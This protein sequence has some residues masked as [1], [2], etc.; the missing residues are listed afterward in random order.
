MPIDIVSSVIF[1][2]P[3][4]IPLW[5]H[6]KVWVPAAATLAAA[7]YYFGGATNTWTR[8]LNGRVYIVTGGTSGLGAQA[9][10]EL[11]RRGAQLILLTRAPADAWTVDFIDD[12]RERTNNFMIYAEP[13]DLLLLY[14][15]RRFATKWLDNNPPRRLDGVVCCAAECIPKGRARQVLADGVEAQ[16]ATNYLAHYHLLTLLRPALHVQPPDR[17]V[18]VVLATC[19]SQVVG[20]VREDD[21]LWEQRTY[22]AARPWRVYG[23]LK[24]LLGMFGRLLQRGVAAYERP[25]KAPCNIKVSVVNPGVM[26]TPSTRRFLSMGS[27]WGLMLYVL[28]WPFWWVF[29]KSASQ[30]VQSVLFAL[31]A[32]VLGAQDG[33]N[34]IQECRIV[35]R[36][37]RE[38]TDWDLQDRVFE[39]TAELI[40]TLEKL[41]AIERKKREKAEGKEPPKAD[42]SA[43][44]QT[45]E[46]LDSQLAV[47]RDAMAHPL[48]TG[49]LFQRTGT[50]KKAKKA[51]KK[52]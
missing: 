13:C 6:V 9:A 21:L 17:D 45:T 41:S 18:R 23:T 15:V 32:P 20:E 49:D 47:M 22:P 35:T 27:V 46:D 26:R 50:G 1:D 34:F 52:A 24:L 3:Q 31:W 11:A 40:A 43:K 16:L 42:L 48:G 29:L 5:D 36:P 33:G 19:L 37:P 51:S 30:G 39:R 14:D 7:K 28:L 8:D 38:Y 12:M 10:Y 44:P 4:V 25:D 2:G